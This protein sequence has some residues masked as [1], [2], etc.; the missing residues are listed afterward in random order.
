M[1]LSG[2]E[3]DFSSLGLSFGNEASR[4]DGSKWGPVSIGGISFSLTL[5]SSLIIG[6]ILVQVGLFDSPWMIALI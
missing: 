3:I 1:F 6:F 2:M 5:V 4:S